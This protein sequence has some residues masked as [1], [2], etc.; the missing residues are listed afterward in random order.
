VLKPGHKVL[1]RSQPAL[2]FTALRVCCECVY[3]LPK[4]FIKIFNLSQNFYRQEG[5][6]ALMDKLPLPKIHDLWDKDLPHLASCLM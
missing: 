5:A 3:L 6:A 2:I 1:G 4:T